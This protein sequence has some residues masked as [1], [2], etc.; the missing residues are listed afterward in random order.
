MRL[1]LFL[2]IGTGAFA[3]AST[4]LAD[5]LVILD[6]GNTDTDFVFE[7]PRIGLDG[8]IY[9]NLDGDYH[10]SVAVLDAN[11]SFA[12]AF[13]GNGTRT[14]TD[15]CVVDLD[16]GAPGGLLKLR[17]D[18]LQRTDSA[19]DPFWT[20]PPFMQTLIHGTTGGAS[21]TAMVRQTDGKVIAGGRYVLTAMGGQ[22]SEDWTLARLTATG[23]MDVTFNA[24]AVLVH[25][26][27]NVGGLA[28][29]QSLHVR[30][31]GQILAIGRVQPSPS[32]SVYETMLARYNAN[33]TN[34]FSFGLNGDMRFA[35]STGESVVDSTERVYLAGLR[36]H[37]TR[38]TTG[39]AVDGTYAGGT[40]NPQLKITDIALDSAGRVVIFG[41]LD[42]AGVG[43]G[44]IA[45]FDTSG[46]PDAS[47]SG[48]G[49]VDFTFPRPAVDAC[50]GSLQS[51]DKPLLACAIEGPADAGAA[52]PIDFAVVRFTASG[53]LDTTFGAAQ[54]D[55]DQ[56]PD[57]FTFGSVTANAGA[58]S[59]TAGPVTISGTNMASEVR[60]S[61]AQFSIG[62]TLTWLS[63]SFNSRGPLIS[64]GQTLCLRAN[65]SATLGAVVTATASVGGRVGTFVVTSSA[66]PADITPNPFTFTAQTGVAVNA[67]VESNAVTITGIEGNSPLAIV[68]GSFSKGCTGSYRGG[69]DTITNGETI[70]VQQVA[71]ATANTQKTTTLTI[72]SVQGTFVTTTMAASGGGSSGGGGGGGGGALDW[73]S[74]TG[75]LLAIGFTQR[76]RYST[77]HLSP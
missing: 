9:L 44:Y 53:T 33:G 30:S 16:V 6:G 65:A 68:N 38:L 73:G 64:S 29:I 75:L 18:D 17:P 45:R 60:V 56:Y 7:A 32:V 40:N 8:R 52:P 14:F 19:L 21:N 25:S 5:G 3:W 39:F 54:V 41:L 70:C 43:H 77:R 27:P 13:S 36:G 46:N 49:V 37:V 57:A 58:V 42:V 20:S 72:G 74:V 59:I 51:D 66:T 50:H 22:P 26:L 67:V 61:G 31:N 11:G 1:K 71:A 76:R 15:A 47:F 48:T 2:L 55:A 28:S 35:D 34:D 10:C 12:P 63:T 23:A 62:C 69:T 4:A 24:G